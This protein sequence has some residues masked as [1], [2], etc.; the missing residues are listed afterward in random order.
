MTRKYSSI[1]IETTLANSINTTDTAI[2][3]AAG[4]ASTLLGGVVLAPANADIFTVAI[5]PDTNNEEI[6]FITANS[7]SDFT[8]VRSRA[9][10]AAIS[11]AA[12]ATVR[13]VMTSSDLDYFRDSVATADAAIPKS[14]VTT[15]GD[16]IAAT[17]ASTPARLG[18]GS[19]GQVLTADSAQGTGIKWATPY[20]LP[21]QTGNAGKYL[22]TNGTVESWAEAEKATEIFALNTTREW[23]DSDFSAAGNYSMVVD[24]GTANVFVYNSSNQLINEFNVTTTASVNNIAT[25]FTRLE[26]VGSTTLNLSIKPVPAVITTAGGVLS[27]DFIT[28][29]GTYG[30][31]TG[32]A[33]GGTSGYIAG[34]L[35][36]VVV[37]GGGG[38]GG[39]GGVYDGFPAAGFSGGNGGVSYTTTPITL[40]GT[41]TFTIGAGGA[42]GSSSPTDGGNGTSSVGFGY[43]STGGTG[44]SSIYG[45]RTPGVNGTPALPSNTNVFR[46]A[47]YTEYG[48]GKA[49]VGQSMNAGTAGAQGAILILRWTP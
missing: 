27:L 20:A 21:S 4:T 9:G 47:S 10:S 25:A 7:G 43:T 6:V 3:V 15:K 36:H 18:V 26:A 38:G 35:A 31:G 34:Q 14:T 28:G 32:T 49:G 5:D 48:Y 1:S 45:T 13:H 17:A 12:G 46:P 41:Y 39:G 40:T 19:N 33:T 44:G 37:F 24:T 42:G 16:L 11:H 2:T 22:S 8:I 23:L 30:V 29:S